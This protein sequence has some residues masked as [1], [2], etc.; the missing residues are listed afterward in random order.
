VPYPCACCK[1]GIPRTLLTG[2]FLPLLG[3]MER[4]TL[5]HRTRKDGAP[6]GSEDVKGWATRPT[7][8]QSQMIYLR[9]WQVKPDPPIGI[10][11]CGKFWDMLEAS[12]GTWVVGPA[13]GDEF[14]VS[15][16]V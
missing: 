16:S 8:R 1:G 13:G 12:V 9:R 5:S 4:P 15:R 11:Q 10:K 7:I 14:V 3:E 2:P 6:S